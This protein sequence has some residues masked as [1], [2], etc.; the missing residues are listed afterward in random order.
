MKDI[1]SINRRNLEVISR[2]NRRRHFPIV[3]DKVLTKQYLEK[4]R[5]PFSHTI[6]VI[7]SFF[8]LEKVLHLLKKQETF[9]VKPSRGRAGGGILLLEKSE[10]VWKTPSGSR[11]DKDALIKHFGDILFG[12]YSFGALGDS[13]LIEKRI[14][15]HKVFRNI[16]ASGVADIRVITL[17]SVPM[18]AMLRIPTVKSD[19]KANLH[20]GA[21]GVA[22][23][24]ERGLTEGAYLRNRKIEKHPDTD[25]PLTG[26]IIPDWNKIL[27]YAVRASNVVPLGYLGI[28][29]VVDEK[30]GPLILELNARPGLQIQAINKKGLR[31]LINRIENDN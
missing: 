31:P 30:R 26:I 27:D 13:V 22:V 19:G 2:Y 24:I 8:D 23:S 20:Q 16:F 12:V 9:V 6:A 3:D 5:I 15:P 28:D 29:F 21:I 10:D 4:G 14:Y 11:V 1:L 25:S 18:M 7:N 17:K